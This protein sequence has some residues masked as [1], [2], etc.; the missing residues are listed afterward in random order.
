MHTALKR[1]VVTQRFF[2]AGTREYLQKHGCT[3]E[4]AE[5]PPGEADGNLTHEQLVGILRGAS[6]WIVGHARVTRELMAALPDLQ[7]ISRRGVGYDRIDCQAAKELGKVVAIAAGGNAEAVADHVLALMLAGIRRVRDFH[8]RMNNGCWEIETTGD[9]HRKTVGIIGYGHI[10]KT[11]AKRLSGFDC[12]ILVHTANPGSAAKQSG[13]PA[14]EYVDL[15]TLL[16]QSDVVTVHAPLTPATRFLI[17]SAALNTMKPSAFVV[18]TARGGLVEDAHLL[19]ALRDGVIGGAGLDVFVSEADPAYASVTRA[20]LALPNVVATPHTAAS[21]EQGLART[22]RVAAEAVV[23][24][25]S[26][27]PIWADCVIVDGRQAA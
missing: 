19:Q 20:L 16:K 1:V 14:V 25:L 2:D 26:S 15:R 7:V 3:V 21:T 22:N 24:V 5:L 27:S 4:I 18:N 6:A 17:D 13:I 10:G 11:V 12:R 9:L 8:S 23:A